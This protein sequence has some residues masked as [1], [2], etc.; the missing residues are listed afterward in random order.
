MKEYKGN[1]SKNISITIIGTTVLK[2][3]SLLTAPLVSHLIH[4]EQYGLLSTFLIWVSIIQIVITLQ[5]P[6][7]ILNANIDYEK[8]NYEKFINSIIVFTTSV[9]LVLLLLFT[10]IGQFAAPVLKIDY[11]MFMLL[12][13]VCWGKGVF[14]CFLAKYMADKRAKAYVA[15]QMTVTIS[16]LVFA[17]G[18]AFIMKDQP[19]I[20]YAIGY[21]IGNVA[22]GLAILIFRLYTYGFPKITA[23]KEHMRF[24]LRI[25]SPMI[26]HSVSGLI[27]LQADRYMLMI[28]RGPGETGVYSMSYNIGSVTAMLWAAINTA[29]VPFFF[30]YYKDKLHDSINEKVKNAST[31]FTILNIGFLMIFPEVIRF[32]I[33][34]EYWGGLTVIPFM[35]ITNYFIHLY[36]YAVN[37]EHYKKKTSYIAIGSISAAAANIALNLLWI[38]KYGQSGAVI[39]TLISYMLL[40]LY[41]F[42][43]AK[44]IIGDFPIKLSR[45]M[46]SAMIFF[47]SVAF[48]YVFEGFPAMRW[49][50]ALITAGYGVFH[51]YKRKGI[52]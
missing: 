51:V 33:S 46:P 14:A 21:T 47:A 41:H 24:A 36:T 13:P 10:G 8:S 43:I 26:I 48:F 49:A 3:V 17:L 18:L 6:S 35:V 19:H 30:S 34:K 5:T 23:I 12:I 15:W 4:K 27:L 2:V 44:K 16:D 38:P 1:A 22:I 52:I 11:L 25:S 29:I 39:A 50:A 20:G 31:V 7:S 45:I 28:I 32:A 42:I 40:F 9:S 37:Y